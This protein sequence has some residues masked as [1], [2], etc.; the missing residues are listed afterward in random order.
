[1]KIVRL[2]NL[3][4]YSITNVESVYYYMCSRKVSFTI[5]DIAGGGKIVS[6]F[7][8]RAVVIHFAITFQFPS[9]SKRRLWRHYFPSM[10][11]VIFSIDSSDRERFEE[12]KEELDMLLSDDELNDCPFLVM[13]NK[14]DLPKCNAS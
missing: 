4:V 10:Q 12:C 2:E 5:W 8:L 1:M 9:S 7:H 14:Q 3:D 6:S 13:A 11:A